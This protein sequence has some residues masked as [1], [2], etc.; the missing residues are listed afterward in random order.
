MG[1]TESEGI[2]YGY[3]RVSTKYQKIE[4]QVENILNRYPNAIIY[5]EAYTGTKMDGRKELD[6]IIKKA[7]C[8]DKIV[9]DEVSRMSRNADEGFALYK[10]LFEKGICLEFIKE[11]HIDT[12]TYRNALSNVLALTG[13]EVADIYIE[14]TNRVLML[15]A[16]KQIRIAFDQAQAEVDHLHDRTKEGMR[17]SGAGQKISVSRTGKKYKTKKSRTAKDVIRKHCKSFG[18]SLSNEETWKLAGISK[19]TFYKYLQEIRSESPDL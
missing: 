14:A 11:P 2:V 17:K 3:A 7:T 6:K 19:M 13:N 18:G 5:K 9:F 15:L 1:A 8:K 12:D 16:E 10:E 4:R